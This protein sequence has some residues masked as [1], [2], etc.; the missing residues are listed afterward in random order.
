MLRWARANL[1]HGTLD[2]GKILEAGSYDS[3]WRNQR[4]MTADLAER[5]AR[6]GVKMPYDSA[7]IGLSWML[8]KR[9]G[10]WTVT[11]G[12]GDL[13]FRSDILLVPD[14]K[15]GIVLMTNSGT[16]NVQELTGQ[17]LQALQPAAAPAH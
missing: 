3:L 16:N 17:L 14:R 7:A 9:N 2:G 6:A 1:A 5:A 10:V 15:I 8:A 4:D 11:H 13:G 12:G